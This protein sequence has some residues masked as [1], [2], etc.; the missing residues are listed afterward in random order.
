MAAARQIT[1]QLCLPLLRAS[2]SNFISTPFVRSKRAMLSP[3]QQPVGLV[4]QVAL[5]IVVVLSTISKDS[6]QPAD[7]L[8]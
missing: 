7:M 5:A 4:P 6:E 3:A 2:S 1:K 8:G